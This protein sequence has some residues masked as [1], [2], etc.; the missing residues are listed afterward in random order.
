MS[1][2]KIPPSTTAW[3]SLS[4]PKRPD[5]NMSG[6]AETD[7]ENQFIGTSDSTDVVF[8]TNN[9]EALRLGAIKNIGVGVNEPT[10][11][12]EVSGTVRIRENLLVDSLQFT[13]DQNN[14]A[15]LRALLVIAR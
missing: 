8:R 10:A 15:S 11:K 7:P 2:V 14:P 3:L 12:L 13:P 4:A 1:K 9:I 5:W 6:N